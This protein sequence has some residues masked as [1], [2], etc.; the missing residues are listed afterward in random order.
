MLSPWALPAVLVQIMV[1]HHCMIRASR[2]LTAPSTAPGP[3]KHPESWI[4]LRMHRT[5]PPGNASLSESS[6]ISSLG[7]LGAPSD[8]SLSMFVVVCGQN[9]EKRSSSIPRSRS[10]LTA[11]YFGTTPRLTM[12]SLLNIELAWLNCCW[13]IAGVGGLLRAECSRSGKIA[14]TSLWRRCG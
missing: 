8:S 3:C 11:R 10:G 2:S 9:T 5:F 1:F 13:W 4:S 14:L 7:G 6:Y 12:A